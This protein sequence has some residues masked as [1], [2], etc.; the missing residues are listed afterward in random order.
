MGWTFHPTPKRPPLR[1]LFVLCMWGGVTDVITHAKFH[2]NRFSS[3]G[4]PGG[5][6][7]P[8]PIGLDNGSY[9]SVTRPDSLPKNVIE[10][11]TD[12]KT[13]PGWR[14]QMLLDRLTKKEEDKSNN[15]IK[16]SAKKRSSMASVNIRLAGLAQ[17]RRR[18]ILGVR[19]S[20]EAS[21]R[22]ANRPL[23]RP[24]HPRMQFKNECRT[25]RPSACRILVSV[26]SWQVLLASHFQSR[27]VCEWQQ[28]LKMSSSSLHVL[29]QSVSKTSWESF[30]MQKMFPCLIQ[31]DF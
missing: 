2:L 26:Q 28:M 15:Q 3:F 13:T 19:P 9:N 1:T 20:P 14:R 18:L 21:L 6:N 30:L 23:I 8:F 22:I 10:R 25:G 16:R 4:S 31:Y 12:G 27:E 7:S 29:S 17:H 5:R 11:R 24:S